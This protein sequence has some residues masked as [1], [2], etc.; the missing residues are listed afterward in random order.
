M[1]KLQI[2]VMYSLFSL[3]LKYIGVMQIVLGSWTCHVDYRWIM[4]SAVRLFL[5][6]NYSYH[7]NYPLI[8]IKIIPECW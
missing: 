6:Y 7:L 4:K 8:V 2:R 5:H 3:H 1:I